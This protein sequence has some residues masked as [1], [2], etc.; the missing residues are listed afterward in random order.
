MNGK[1]S[2]RRPQQVSEQEL[3]QRW[4]ETFGAEAALQ[5]LTE[6]AQD[7]HMGYPLFLQ[8]LERTE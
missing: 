4:A 8:R 1:G 2:T 5:E 6:I 3:E 7:Y